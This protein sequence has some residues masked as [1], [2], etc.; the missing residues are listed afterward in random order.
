ARDD[1]MGWIQTTIPSG[2]EAHRTPPGNP[3]VDALLDDAY[4][5][6][7]AASATAK[8]PLS[9]SQSTR[10]DAGRPLTRDDFLHRGRSQ[11]GTLGSGNHFVELLTDDADSVWVMLH[12]G[13]R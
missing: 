13:S 5:A 3:E 4:A 9:T 10:P 2:N 12:S 6:M 11:L 1:I 7:E 8:L